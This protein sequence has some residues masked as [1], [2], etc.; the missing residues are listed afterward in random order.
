MGS[1]VWQAVAKSYPS[2]LAA[3]AVNGVATATSETLLV[4]VVADLF[5][6]D[7]HGLWMGVYL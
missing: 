7:E 2:L 6:V 5:F 1:C 3:R 4:Q